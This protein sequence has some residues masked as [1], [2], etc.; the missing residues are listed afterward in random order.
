MSTP[1]F[2]AL[3]NRNKRSAIIN[4]KMGADVLKRLVE[5]ADVLIESYRPGV[6]KRLG[7]DYESL[8]RV[9]PRLVYCALSGY[10]QSGPYI[11]R[12]GHDLNYTSLAGITGAMEQPQPVGGQMADVGGAYIAVAGIMAALFRREREG[13]GGFVDTSLF[14]SALPFGAYAWSEAVTLGVSA[15]HGA[16]SGGLAC[17]QVYR[18]RDERLV[19]LAALEPK[20]W[21]NFCA[22][23]DRTDL[24]D[25]YLVPDR[26]RYLKGEV[27]EIFARRDAEEWH[28]LL[29]DA[30]CCFA[31]V[32]P[33]SELANDEQVSARGMAGVDA[34]GLWMRSPI[35][36]DGELAE[37][38]ISP[39]YGVHTRTVLREAGYADVEI[40]ELFTDGK[41]K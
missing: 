21:S 26:Q 15:G 3:S 14:E 27:A 40:D 13:V 39:E 32:A 22:T 17:Y 10:G 23:V 1:S 36:L 2:F 6:M 30:E 24:V 28:A 5:K 29:Y 34:F 4:L 16:L 37:R 31:L 38:G 33:P 9:N 25:D 12:E 19:S 7:C 20:F 8:K 18:T 35:R 41:V 11:E